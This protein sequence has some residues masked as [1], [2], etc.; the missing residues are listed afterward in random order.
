MHDVF[1]IPTTPQEHKHAYAA[2][3]EVFAEF[4][5]PDPRGSDVTRLC[6]LAYDPR[7]IHNLSHAP[8]EWEAPSEDDVRSAPLRAPTQFTGKAD[9]QALD[10]IP[11]DDYEIWYQVGLALYREGQPIDVWIKWSGK[12]EK[13]SQNTAEMYR[14]KWAS[15]AQERENGIT[16]G[17]VMHHAKRHGYTPKHKGGREIKLTEADILSDI[18]RETLEDAQSFIQTVLNSDLSGQVFALRVDTGAGK[19]EKAIL[20]KM[21]VQ[22]YLSVAMISVPRSIVEQSL[23]R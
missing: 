2:V 16:W 5:E 19:T 12:S 15:F 6:L 1:P 10:Y 4:G 7:P 23:T 20:I 18:K 9:L 13:A 17:S 22:F 11:S 14:S 3:C 8:T 21:R